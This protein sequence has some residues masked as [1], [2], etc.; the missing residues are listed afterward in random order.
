MTTKVLLKSVSGGVGKSFLAA[1]LANQLFSQQQKVVLFEVS[2]C[3]V[4]PVFFG[5]RQLSS[6]IPP[7]KIQQY[8]LHD[9]FT[10]FCLKVDHTR[11]LSG[12]ESLFRKALSGINDLHYTVIIDAQCGLESL[13]D[14]GQISL[15]LEV[16]ACEPCSIATARVHESDYVILNKKDLRSPLSKD[17][18]TL[19]R[20]LFGD[21]L[22]CEIHFDMAIQEAYANKQ[23]LS[24]YAPASPALQDLIRLSAQVSERLPQRGVLEPQ[25]A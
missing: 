13:F 23:L 20:E 22:L 21:R 10:L 8:K 7:W 4:L 12:V 6:E 15:S 19:S 17:G 11:P 25:P 14:S 24:A 9:D 1:N 5:S 18:V 3:P 2:F 16:V